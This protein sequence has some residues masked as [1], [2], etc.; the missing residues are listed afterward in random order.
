MSLLPTR[1]ENVRAGNAAGERARRERA[2]PSLF[3]PTHS[4]RTRPAQVD[5]FADYEPAKVKIGRP[6]PDPVV[7][8]S[9]M[10]RPNRSLFVCGSCYM[11]AE[12]RPVLAV[13]DFAAGPDA[14][15]SSA[16][17]AH[18]GRPAL[19]PAA[20][21]DHLRV[22]AARH[23]AAER[24][25]F[26]FSARR[27]RGHRQG[28]TGQENVL[29]RFHSDGSTE[30][31][32]GSSGCS[33]AAFVHDHSNQIA[34]MVFE[35][36]IRGRRKAVWFSASGDLAADAK[37]D[38]SDIGAG[39]TL[40]SPP[41]LPGCSAVCDL[42]SL[43]MNECSAAPAGNIPMANLPALPYG[44]CAAVIAALVLEAS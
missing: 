18:R 4:E 30:G 16:P 26:W 21:V 33:L 44:A 34:G 2:A 43:P 36:W 29:L 11:I 14:P 38:F 41:H 20:R 3:C 5:T 6:H 22:D 37:R 8:T 23:L 17:A 1:C 42:R 12:D 40:T 28:Q 15:A 19:E 39:D 9:S 7:E 27:R 31:G 35:N 10:V 24:R 13:L 25:T 32:D